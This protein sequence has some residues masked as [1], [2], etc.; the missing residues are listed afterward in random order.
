MKI[1]TKYPNVFVEIDESNFSFKII[2]VIEGK[3]KV[4]RS[5]VGRA[6]RKAIKGKPKH[7]MF[8][9]RL[10]DRFN[11]FDDAKQNALNFVDN[12]LILK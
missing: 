2:Q 3:N 1:E 6:R 10:C 7:D 4:R 12:F 9:N 5:V 11:D 8:G